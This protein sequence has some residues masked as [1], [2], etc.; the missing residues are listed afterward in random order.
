MQNAKLCCTQSAQ[1]QGGF[2]QLCHVTE[3]LARLAEA[4]ENTFVYAFRP[5]A[6][7]LLAATVMWLASTAGCVSGNHADVY[8]V[9]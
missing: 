4:A 8:C 5:S 2:S 3:K 6:A 1:L 9:H 7:T